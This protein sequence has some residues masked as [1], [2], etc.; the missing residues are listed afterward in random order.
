MSETARLR[1]ILTY[2]ASMLKENAEM[3]MRLSTEVAALIAA[4]R[5]LDPTFDDVLNQK[6]LEMAEAGGEKVRAMLSQFEG[7]VK[8]I[9]GG[10][11]V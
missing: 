9:E 10:W 5:G 6:R 1:P 8:L 11:I 3:S 7:I 2:F 4:V